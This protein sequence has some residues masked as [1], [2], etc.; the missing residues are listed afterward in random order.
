MHLAFGTDWPVAPLNPLI[1]TYAAVTRRTLDDRN[2][3]GWFPEQKLSV[4][5]ALSIYTAGSAYAEFQEHDKG[6][7]EVG[8]LADFVLL[9]E[10]PFHVDPTHLRDITVAGTW[11]GGH[12]IYTAPAAP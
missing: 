8:K 11:V 12:R 7:L 1:S 10:D 2:P 9:T 6:T 4:G 5:E 3:N